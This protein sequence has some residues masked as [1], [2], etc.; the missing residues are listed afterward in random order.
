M[1]LLLLISRVLCRLRLLSCNDKRRL[2]LLTSIPDADII[3]TWKQRFQIKLLV[4]FSEE[5][6]QNPLINCLSQH[7]NY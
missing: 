3:H 2:A 6:H 7:V 4:R 1:R 5:F